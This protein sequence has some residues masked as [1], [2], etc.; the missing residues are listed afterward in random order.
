MTTL[1]KSVFAAASFLALAGC[2]MQYSDSQRSCITGLEYKLKSPSSLKLIRV[3]S[4]EQFYYPEELKREYFE[5][6][7]TLKVEEYKGKKG[8]WVRIDMIEYDASN[9]F[10][11]MLRDNEHCHNAALANGSRVDLSL[12]LSGED[13]DLPQDRIRISGF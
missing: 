13:V 10:G 12:R 5:A 2:G 3:S 8:T 11:V 6:Q 4:M 9:S 1:V 7:G